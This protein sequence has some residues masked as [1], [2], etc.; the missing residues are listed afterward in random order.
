MNRNLT[1]NQMLM[2]DI[3]RAKNICETFSM[4]RD[5]KWYLENQEAIISCVCVCVSFKG[6]VMVGLL[7]NAGL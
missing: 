6:L 5:V 1:L 2:R 7:E 4:Q 3:K